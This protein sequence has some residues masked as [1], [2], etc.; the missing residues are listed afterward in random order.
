MVTI[1]LC[2][3]VKN[4]E[5]VL[6]RCL[7]SIAAVVDEIILIDTGST[8]HTRQIAQTYTEQ[9]YTF[10]WIDDFSAAR[11][12]SFSKASMDYCLWLDADD[13]FLE[14]DR[15]ALLKLKQNLDRN[16]DIVMMRYCTGFGS[17][18][19]PTFWY[20]RERLIKNDGRYL[21]KGAVHEAIVPSGV[22]LYSDIAVY[23]KKIHPGDPDRNLKIY[24][25]LLSQGKNFDCRERYYYAR[26]LYYHAQYQQTIEQL[27]L[28][29]TEPDAWLENKIEAC[30]LLADCYRKLN[31]P[32]DALLSLLKS[33]EYDKPR[34][35]ICCEIGS[36]F[37][38]S[39]QY[40]I[41]V[42]WFQTALHCQADFKRG[43]FI[44]PDCYQY[45]PALQLCV[46]YDRMGRLEEANRYNE[47]AG[48]VKPDSP[49][50]LQN[51]IYFQNKLPKNG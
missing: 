27:Q 24:Q 43:G 30:L 45:V 41:A 42:F 18:G 16:T 17:E 38:D 15:S 33:L 19:Q 26:E 11:N 12:F 51:R 21:W 29:L 8:D 32:Q 10:P 14:K 20:Y 23:H 1:S 48:Q 36:Y 31:S 40:D 47:L 44:Q 2:M 22:I 13:I 28:F 7:D 46:C 37:L 39:G 34:A 3:I 35:E 25:K 50:F 49:A 4:E 6:Q 5:D 9:V